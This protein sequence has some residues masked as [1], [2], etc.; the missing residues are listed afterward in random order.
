VTTA[1]LTALAVAIR[2]GWLEVHL[3][4]SGGQG[5][6]VVAEYAVVA[7]AK[8]LAPPANTSP[9]PCLPLLTQWFPGV[10]V[11]AGQRSKATDAAVIALLMGELRSRS[12]A[13]NPQPLHD[14]AGFE[15][16]R[17]DGLQAILASHQCRAV[18]FML[19]REQLVTSGRLDDAA[20]ALALCWVPLPLAHTATP[21]AMV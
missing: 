14:I 12:M 4:Q 8:L 6:L 11:G 7:S 2:T 5:L 20:A 9:H 18:A 15:Q 13:D 16:G 21:M 17:I 19:E 3:V 1:E 10:A